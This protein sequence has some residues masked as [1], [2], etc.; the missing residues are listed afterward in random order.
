[1]YKS[2]KINNSETLHLLSSFFFE[3]QVFSKHSVQF[4]K[5]TT[6]IVPGRQEEEKNSTPGLLRTFQEKI[7]KEKST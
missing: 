4:L 7:S 1:M 5:T 2:S 6:K 3:R